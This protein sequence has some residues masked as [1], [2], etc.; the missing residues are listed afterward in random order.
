MGHGINM[1]QGMP[2]GMPHGMGSVN[3]NGPQMGSF[4]FMSDDGMGQHFQ[5][6]HMGMNK[7]PP[8]KSKVRFQLN[9]NIMIIYILEYNTGCL[10]NQSFLILA[11]IIY[12]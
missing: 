6:S 8:P 10:C 5:N 2:Q 4:S 3:S 1:S 12:I 7:P 11:K 9:I